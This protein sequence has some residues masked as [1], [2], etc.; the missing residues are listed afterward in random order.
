M[1]PRKASVARRSAATERAYRSDWAAFESWCLLGFR[2]SM[3]ASPE[4]V[5]LYIQSLVDRAKLSTLRRKLAAIH[6]THTDR[7]HALSRSQPLVDLLDELTRRHTGD[8]NTRPAPSREQVSRMVHALPDSIAGVRDRALILAGWAVACRPADLI[9]LDVTDIEL[10]AR[11]AELSFHRRG[12][13]PLKVV[14][15]ADP[16]PAMCPV[17][18][19]RTWLKLLGAK[20]GPVFRPVSR[21]GRIGAGR[22]SVQMFRLVLR[23]VALSAG[24][25][26]ENLSAD[27][28]CAAHQPERRIA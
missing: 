21:Y 14:V 12:R 19:M 5:M 1:S 22:L 15:Q 26:V 25:A 2:A 6:S 3:P 16:D 28:L 20:E 7:G 10:S 13:A 11:E 4:T 24:V 23:R 8:S 18:W 17:R 9:D 27:G